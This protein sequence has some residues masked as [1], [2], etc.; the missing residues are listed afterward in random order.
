QTQKENE[1]H[2][3]AATS[4]WQIMR[5]S[6]PHLS[7]VDYPAGQA[8]AVGARRLLRR[9]ALPIDLWQGKQHG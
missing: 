4:D 6:A 2:S 5:D 3:M 1:T 7:S 9:A 8:G